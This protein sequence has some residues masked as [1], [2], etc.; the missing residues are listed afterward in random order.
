MDEKA[1]KMLKTY[2]QEHLID[3]YEH[4]DEKKKETFSNQINSIDFEK[5]K[6]LFEQTKDEHSTG[7][8]IIE[9]IKYCTAEKL[10]EDIKQ[11]YI[12]IGEQVI[13]D[14]KYAVVMVA[15]GQGTRL[16][17]NGPK[18]TFDMGLASHKSL[19]EIFCDKLKKAKADYG[20]TIP[21]YIMTS[22]ENNKD[23]VDFF[24]KN[25]YFDYKNGIKTFFKQGELPMLDTNG[26]LIIGED[27]LTKE[28]ADGHGGVFEAMI[29]SGVLAEMKEKGIEW[30]FTCAVDNPLAHLVDPLFIGYTVSQN[31]AVSSISVEKSYPEE[32]V[33]VFCKRNGRPS[34]IE[35]TEL[36]DKMRFEKN[37]ENDYLYG[38]AHIMMNMFNINVI[39]DIAK[40]KLP[41]HC[42]FKKC[43]YMDKDGNVVI[44][45]E[46]NA[47]KFESFI[48]DSFSRLDDIGV[49]R[50]KRE[51]CFA[52]IKN[53][54]GLDSPETAR[55]LYEQLSDINHNK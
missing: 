12:K 15:G 36:T 44:A 13:R 31:V 33:G 23:T 40:K 39:N 38:E 35:Y 16:G 34:V 50:Y 10:P 22:K 19:F 6:K 21:W 25:N 27:G 8:D 4:L 48:F 14:N 20:V 18:G 52:P 3:A 24:E 45:N 26:K 32:R 43:N 9:P 7:N 29:N 42:A 55:K 46:P 2:G 41:Y 49:L 53:A 51:E 47:Y 1:I 28:A 54:E 11:K 37:E 17:H 5:M 30:I